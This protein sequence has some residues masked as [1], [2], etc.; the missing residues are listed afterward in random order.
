M[1]APLVGLF[2]PP[3]AGKDTVADRLEDRWG[4][5]RLALADPMREMLRQLNPV[6]GNVV[7]RP[8]R[9]DAA[10]TVHGWRW[11]KDHLP[12]ARALLQRLG[13]EAGRDVL[14][15]DVWLR[16][17]ERRAYPHLIGGTP[18]VVTDI[19]FPNEAGWVTE[20]GGH[21]VR[22]VRPEAEGRDWGHASEGAIPDEWATSTLDNAS[23]LDALHDAVDAFA[24]GHLGR[25][26][27]P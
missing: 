10:V 15:A 16:H 9:L 7:G 24:S 12:E 14:G 1:A 3:R 5:K 20:Q 23:D 27:S 22:V 13:T 19:R 6:V 25:I 8:V 26:P 4:F 2:G 18:V 17:L 21:L 11:V